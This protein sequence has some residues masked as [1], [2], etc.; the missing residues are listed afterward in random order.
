VI[1]DNGLG[2]ADEYLKDIFAMFRRLQSRR[3]YSGVGI[4]LSICK[5]IIERHGGRIGV[6]STPGEGSTFWF[7]LA[8]VEG[9][10]SANNESNTA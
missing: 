3:E 10:V 1:Q 2:I 9:T 8:S 5:K 6:E 4:G 7:T